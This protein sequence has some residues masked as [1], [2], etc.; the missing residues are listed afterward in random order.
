MSEYRILEEKY[1]DRYGKEKQCYYIVQ[2]RKSFLGIRYWKNIKHEIG[3]IY[4]IHSVNTH[5]ESIDAATEFA[6]RVIC[7]CQKKDKWV[8]KIIANKKCK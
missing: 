1:Y 5:F 8:T 7:G 2:Y 3:G 6:E 4:H